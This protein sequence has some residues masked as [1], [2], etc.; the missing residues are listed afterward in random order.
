MG[1]MTMQ[2]ISGLGR[3]NTTFDANS[4]P[5]GRCT[6]E[7]TLGDGKTLFLAPEGAAAVD[8]LGAEAFQAGKAHKEGLQG[9][10]FNAL[11][12]NGG[13]RGKCN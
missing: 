10:L 13:E 11:G 9:M 2:G 4:S 1:D 7:R 6:E 5:A 3:A 12:I 8:K